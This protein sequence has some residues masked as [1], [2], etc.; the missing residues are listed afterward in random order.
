MPLL[1]LEPFL[2]PHDLLELPTGE[3][4]AQGPEGSWWALHSHPRA[5]KSLAR[6]LLGAGVAFFL[7]LYR[8]EWRSQGRLRSSYAPLFPG[9]LFL[10]GDDRARLEALKTNQVARLLPVHDGPELHADLARVYQVM[11]GGLLLEPEERIQP[12]MPVRIVSGA[13]EGLEGKV[14]RRGKGLRFVVEVHFLQRGVSVE[15]EAHRVRP[16][17]EFASQ[18]PVGARR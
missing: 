16:L 11:Q 15:I 4:K 13:L 17:D 7:P 9:Y 6:K 5:E 18:V 12:G 10:H 14:L 3:G 2:Y 1:P 8:K